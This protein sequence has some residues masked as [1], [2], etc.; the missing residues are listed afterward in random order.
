MELGY[1]AMDLVSLVNTAKELG[2]D[3]VILESH[4]NWVDKSAIKS[5]QL[6]AGFMNEYV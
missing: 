1:G 2:V 4:K 3:A 6:S 5:F